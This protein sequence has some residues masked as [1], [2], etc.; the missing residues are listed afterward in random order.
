MEEFYDVRR[1]MKE[2]AMRTGIPSNLDQSYSPI[3]LSSYPPI[4]L[5]TYTIKNSKLSLYSKPLTFSTLIIFTLFWSD[6]PHGDG[7]IG[8]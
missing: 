6:I 3:L 5:Y 1:K 4:L 7:S 8:A 2:F